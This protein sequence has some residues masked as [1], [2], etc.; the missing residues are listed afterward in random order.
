MAK[1]KEPEVDLAD[2][3]GVLL[4]GRLRLQVTVLRDAVGAWMDLVFGYDGGGVWIAFRAEFFLTWCDTYSGEPSSFIGAFFSLLI[5]FISD[6]V[7]GWLAMVTRWV[8]G[9]R[10]TGIFRLTRLSFQGEFYAFFDSGAYRR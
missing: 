7:H 8:L 3:R 10:S 2:E 4:A 1:R 6:F 5:S 9:D